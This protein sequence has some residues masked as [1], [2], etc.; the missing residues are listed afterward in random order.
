MP[1]SRRILLALG[2]TS[3]PVAALGVIGFGSS[4]RS[5]VAE[6]VRRTLSDLT[7]DEEGLQQFATEFET[8]YPKG[9]LKVAALSL[10]LKFAGSSFLPNYGRTRLQNLSEAASQIY[11][12]GSSYFSPS[13][14][15]EKPVLYFR[16]YDPMD[17]ACA[18][19]IAQFG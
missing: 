4:Y 9:A 6:S 10:S 3:V 17:A 15:K 19:P 14:T 16:F 7:L 8:R 12:L 2:V 5:I 13:H 18:N 1:L 11:L